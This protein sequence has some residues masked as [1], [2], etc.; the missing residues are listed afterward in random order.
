MMKETMFEK[1]PLVYSPKTKLL[2]K[3]IIYDLFLPQEYGIQ[4]TQKVY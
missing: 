3:N 4:S 1:N 2:Q